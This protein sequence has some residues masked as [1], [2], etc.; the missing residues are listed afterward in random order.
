M[1]FANAMRPSI[2]IGLLAEVARGNGFAVETLHLNLDFAKV[3]GPGFYD[4]MS[5]HGQIGDWLF[6]MAAFADAA[7]DPEGRYL[8]LDPTIAS[9][10]F[11]RYRLMRTRDEKVGP[12]LDRLV[13]DIG[14]ERFR[15]VGFTS[16][17]S[18]SVASIALAR[19]L[20]A[21]R[22]DLVCVFGGANCEGEMGEELVR[23]ADC[24]DYA[25]N[26]EA[27]SAF[28][29]LLRALRDDRDP[30]AIPGVLC[31]RGGS[32][33][34]NPPAPPYDD[35]DALPV[36]SY[37][38]YFARATRLGVLN[39]VS[40]VRVEL[41]FESARGCWWGQ[42]RHCTFCGLNGTSMSFRAK[43][44][45]RLADE[46]DELARRNGTRRLRAVDN[47]LDP[48]YTD[49]L[50]PA[51][52]KAGAPYRLFYEV[53]ADL[54]RMQLRVLRAAGV[55][56]V[57]PGIESLSSHVLRLMRKGTRASQNVNFLRWA[58]HTGIHAMWN[59]LFGFPDELHEEVACQAEL[60]PKLAHLP[61]PEVACRILLERFSPL[62]EDE[63]AFPRRWIRPAA[64]YAHTYP[65]TVNLDRIAYF[66]DYEL[67]HT[68]DDAEYAPIEAA[69]AT[70]QQRW[71]SGVRPTMTYRIVG[72]EVIVDDCRAPETPATHVLT[73]LTAKAY[74]ACSERA[75][76]AAAVAVAVDASSAAANCALDELHERGL[77]MRDD[78]LF[79]ALALPQC[80]AEP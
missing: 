11:T 45:S 14:W 27:D 43:S 70:W 1:P 47:I 78:R 7:P 5:T 20:K 10:P 29:A 69:V 79:L 4:W 42:V 32:L 48:S 49:T 57:Q 56:T 8:E 38:E 31:R 55:H 66:F 18:Q 41:P 28:P 40:R 39:E 23:T 34:A 53:K 59:V 50:F 17:F 77:M 75:E 33:I 37:E 25:V 26:G 74:V 30:V 68:L 22:P 64:S 61:P 16:T 76:S 63:A 54:D 19:R 71:A 52:A 3:V 62:H 46:L 72:D 44:P 21:R 36:P 2:Q 15:V 12:Y 65:A 73:G 80:T 60:I 58:H 51:L 24:I 67:A 35:M 13:E 9:D 6:S